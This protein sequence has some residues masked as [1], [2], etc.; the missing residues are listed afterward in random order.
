MFT[1]YHADC[2]GQAGNCLYP[3]AVEITDKAS[4]A[5]AVSHDYV[6]AEY[7]GSYRNND[8]FIG[9]NCLPVDCDNDHSEDPEDWKYPSDVAEAFPGVAFAVHYSRNHMKVKNGKPA[10]P[11]FHVFFAIDP[12]T[13]AEQ[14]SSLKKLVNTIFP[15]FDTKALDAARFFFGTK[16]PQVEIFDG[17]MTLTTFLADDDFDADMDSGRYGDLVI[18][19]GSRN[20]TMSHFAGKILK[21]YGNTEE[22][23][24]HFSDLADKCVPP[25]EQTELDAIWRSALRFYGKVADQEDYIPPEKYN[26]DLQL[27]PSDYSDVGQAVVLSREYGDKLRYS[28]STD[29]IVYN[30]S[31]WEESKPKSQ[32]VAQELT[33]RQLEEAETEIKKATDEMV[34]NGAW[35]LLASMGPKRAAAAFTSQQARSFQKYEIATTYRNYAI[36]RRDS[37]YIT[38][39]LKEARPK[40]EINQKQLDADEFLLNTPSGTY[41]LRLG[42]TAVHEHQ[43]S[44]FITKM[45]TV[46]PSDAGAD[47]WKDALDTFFLGDTELMGYVQEIVGLAAIGKVYIEA[48]IIAYGEGRNGK[49]TFWNTVSRVLGTYSGNMS[50]DTLTVGCKRN[51][52][53]ELAEAKG[54]RLIIAAE[55]EEGMRLNTSNVKQLCSTDEIYAEKKYKDPFSYVPSH[56]LVLYTNHLPKVGA[57]DAGTWRRLIVIPFNAKIEGNSDIKNYADYLYDKAGGAILTWIIEGAQRVIAKDYHIMQPQVVVDAIAKYRENNDWLTHFLDECCE[58]DKA[59]YEKSGELYNAYRSYC[60]QVGEYIRS[61]TDFYVALESAGFERKRT[62]AGRNIHGLRLKSDFMK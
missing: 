40:L 56:T 18:E 46:D 50:A 39:A 19:E 45:T 35:E 52:K 13:D 30:G 15:Y 53:P 6:C 37:K 51:V 48:L 23:R 36:K 22:A 38:S 33:D 21:R 62:N 20:A 41:D 14:Y 61:T 29:Y 55:L 26:L 24:K 2:I 1:I 9:S 27:R 58:V 44:D 59:Y 57:I 16:N 28:P 5:Q 11:K 47:L 25:L 60:M 17:P 3:H 49:S 10:R 12:L 43:A 32:A 31:F 54:K 34:A 8:N 4:L 7:K 42:L